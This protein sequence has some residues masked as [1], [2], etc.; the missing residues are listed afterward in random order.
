LR[1]TKVGSSCTCRRSDRV[2]RCYFDSKEEVVIET[3]AP[4]EVDFT[5]AVS[6]F[7][8]ADRPPLESVCRVLAQTLP[9]VDEQ[10][11]R[12][13]ARVLMTSINAGP[14]ARLSLRRGARQAELAAALIGHSVTPEEARLSTAFGFACLDVAWREW[15]RDIEHRDLQF[16]YANALARAAGLF[17]ELD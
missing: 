10:T 12:L 4:P 11:E 13:R 17:I 16:H 1:T 7:G 3:A 9:G 5:A 8:E 6:E 14:G 15:A 2:C